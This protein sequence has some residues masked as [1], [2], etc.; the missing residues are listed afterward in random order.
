MKSIHNLIILLSLCFMV[1]ACQPDSATKQ[2]IQ[3]EQMSWD[4]ALK[5]A[6]KEQKLIFVDA[7]TTWCKPCKLM[8]QK[9]FT[10][11]ALAAYYNE[12]FINLKLDM[13][14][15]EGINF[16]RS[17]QVRAFPTLLFI[18]PNGKAVSRVMGFRPATMMMQT[19]K[20]LE[21]VNLNS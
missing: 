5:R 16:A 13:E 11:S 10:D 2:G 20:N 1:S 7:Y 8:D 19:A 14:K 18:D 4:S 17:Y 12:N 21:K 6:Q 15:G 3:F 9:T